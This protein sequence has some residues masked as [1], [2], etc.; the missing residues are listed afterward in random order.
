MVGS[1]VGAGRLAIQELGVGV[2]APPGEQDVAVFEA[3][4]AAS[5][6]VGGHSASPDPSP[7]TMAGLARLS[8]QTDQATIGT[9]ALLLPLLPPSLV[10]K[11]V[12]ELDNASHGRVALGVGVGGDYPMEFDASE[13]SVAGRGKRIDEAISLIRQLWSGEPTSWPG[14]IFAMDNVHVH[15]APRQPGG[16][17]IIIAGRQPP[18]MRRAALLGDGWMPYLFSPRRYADSVRMIR[19]EAA[20]LGRSLNGFGWLAYLPVSVDDDGDLARERAT[21]FLSATYRQDFAPVVDRVAVAGTPA[22]VTAR[23]HAFVDAGARHLVLLPAV[24]DGGKSMLLRVL[25]EIAP[26]VITGSHGARDA[27]S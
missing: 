8:A 20:V 10:A 6:W 12:A 3:R 15:P 19:T 24:P 21:E 14:P 17:P 7:E 18:A 11:Q 27:G 16:P 22:E 26:L 23:L 13:A 5:L 25:S 4:G 9:A 1:S 2:V